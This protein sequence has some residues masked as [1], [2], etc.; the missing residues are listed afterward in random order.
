MNVTGSYACMS[1]TMY[2]SPRYLELA[3]PP[4]TAGLRR[5]RPAWNERP[6][7]R[8]PTLKPAFSLHEL[9]LNSATCKFLS[10]LFIQRAL[11]V[12]AAP[13]GRHRYQPP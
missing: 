4:S 13:V 11:L 8:A 1:L 3:Q 10:A 9:P 2:M 7:A 6:A 12:H 5:A